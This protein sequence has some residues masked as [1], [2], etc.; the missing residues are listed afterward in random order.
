MI[1]SVESPNEATAAGDIKIREFFGNELI[2][3]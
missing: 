2:K 1:Y 3:G